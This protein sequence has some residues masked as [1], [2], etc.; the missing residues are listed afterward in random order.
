[1]GGDKRKSEGSEGQ[2][3]KKACFYAPGPASR[4]EVKEGMQ[5][6]L[7][8]VNHLKAKAAIQEIKNLMGQYFSALATCEAA[9]PAP[10]EVPPEGQEPTAAT[11]SVSSRLGAEL[12]AMKHG[13][14]KYTG[15][16][17][18]ET[19]VGGNF[20]VATSEDP[21]E[22]VLRI[23]KD[24]CSSRQSSTRFIY[25]LIPC[26]RVCRPYVPTIK[27]AAA[28]VWQTY[29]DG[30]RSRPS[31]SD[32]ARGKIRYMISTKA[33]SNT[34]LEGAGDELKRDIAAA[35]NA[36]DFAV[37]LQAPDVVLFVHTLQSVTLI[38]VG[39]DV[40]RLRDFNIH[41]LATKGPLT[42]EELAAKR[43]RKAAASPLSSSTA[44]DSAAQAPRGEEAGE[45]PAVQPEAE[46][47][48]P[49]AASDAPLPP[50]P[51]KPDGTPTRADGGVLP[52]E[53]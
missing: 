52:G 16:R 30:V 33:R 43:V 41:E 25:K 49:P 45:T 29:A 34:G 32:P 22:L 40:A 15:V 11:G 42:E 19:P 5:G 4:A 47:A 13:R 50:S 3:G 27:S 1:M 24:F 26:Q 8:T 14:A 39:E 7:F 17:V 35:V 21:R 38:G 2:R 48:V 31:A 18:L 20:F 28:E 6:I 51:P 10:K 12:A 23:S 37:H 53:P 9:P 44:P 46:A 36:E